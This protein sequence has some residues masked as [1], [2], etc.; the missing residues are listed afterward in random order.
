M[1][2]KNL[3]SVLSFEAIEP[4]NGVFHTELSV[5]LGKLRSGNNYDKKSVDG[6][7]INDL[8]AKHTGMKITLH[9]RDEL[10]FA[11]MM[12]PPILDKNHPLIPDEI[13]SKV[14]PSTEE[15]ISMADKKIRG[16][17]DIKTSKV[18]GDFS[19][20][21]L[22][23]FIGSMI[24][25]SP[26]FSNDEV[27]AVLLHEIG[28][29]FTF[30]EF[31]G[32]TFRTNFIMASISQEFNNTNDLDRRKKVLELAEKETGTEFEDIEKVAA[33]RTGDMANT[34][35]ITDLTR[36]M[37]SE[38][39][40]NLYNM[41]SAEML[42][43]D[44]AAR[45]GASKSLA[46]ALDKLYRLAGEQQLRST[47]V[48]LIIEAVKI[49]SFAVLTYNLWRTAASVALLTYP[50]VKEHDSPYERLEKLENYL[51][52]RLKKRDLTD[53]EKRLIHDDLDFISR[54]KNE[55]SN[56]DT[57]YRFL[58]ESVVPMRRRMKKQAEIQR[59]LEALANNELYEKA[60]KLEMG[61][62]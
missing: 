43:D 44:F 19:K 30:F 39:G 15:V 11:A 62:Q 21:P 25:K 50:D 55:Y 27:A 52:G 61:A 28:H 13:R 1:G 17:V 31:L 53:E 47:I 7:G 4:Q 51:I 2:K 10:G 18:S 46:G 56:R 16:V 20:V 6:S 60:S 42:A 23:M 58:I 54:T 8:I 36:R 3:R 49:T 9:V 38:L 12:E 32:Y 33:H 5:A 59:E 24:L 45:H 48:Y 22:D 37:H 35:I 40:E 29:A 26:K 34:I 57:F 14:D 41:R